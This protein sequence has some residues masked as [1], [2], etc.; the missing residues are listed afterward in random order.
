MKIEFHFLLHSSVKQKD[1]KQFPPRDQFSQTQHKLQNECNEM[2]INVEEN[3]G[4]CVQLR[5][6]SSPT[7]SKSSRAVGSEVDNKQI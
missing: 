6:N 1:W 3:S 4:C 2:Q 5:F 7:M